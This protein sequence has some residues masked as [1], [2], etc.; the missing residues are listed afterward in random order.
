M[1]GCVKFLGP[2][3]PHFEA[4]FFRSLLSLPLVFWLLRRR[5]AG[6]RP[7]RPWLML[8]RGLSGLFAM[9]CYFYALQR[10]VL[11]DVVIVSRM[12][13]IFIALLAPLLLGERTTRAI[14]VALVTSFVGV[15][16]VIKPGLGLLN[17]PGLLA[18]A[19]SVFSALAHISVRKLNATDPPERIVVWFTVIVG[20]GGLAA[21]LP[22]FV[23]PTPGQLALL[24]G[25]ALGA[26]MGQLLMTTAYSRD[27]APAVS[28]ASYAFVVFGILGGWA[29][30]GEVPDALS[31]LGAA[32]VVGAGVLLAFS[33]RVAGGGPS[34]L[35]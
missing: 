12:Q 31:L 35:S 26:T 32:V 15:V 20:C 30:W 6:V 10:G 34:S 24:L 23:V 8:A 33:R 29:V 1:F 7:R 3:F 27:T 18:L 16:L 4:I 2:G 28:T 25:V 5:G 14:A 9:G 17:L 22:A 19:G 11:A 13:P 21:A